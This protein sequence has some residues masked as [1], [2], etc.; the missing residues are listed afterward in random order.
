MHVYK[1]PDK[2]GKGDHRCTPLEIWKIARH[3]IGI[4][5]WGL[6]PACNS[7]STI[8][9]KICWDGSNQDCNGLVQPWFGHVWLNFPFSNSTIWVDT[10][11]EQ[12][13]RIDEIRSLTILSSADS[14]TAWWHTLR[15]AC[16]SWAAWNGRIHF[17]LPDKPEGSPGGGVH[18]S[19][20]GPRSTRWRRVFEHFGHTTG[21]GAR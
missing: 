7:F 2:D 1:A 18:L 14:S 3:A 20:I 8:P 13:N 19:Y 11:I 17:P 15:K 12:S 6:D 21:V 5:E 9:A 10:A 4:K 16:D